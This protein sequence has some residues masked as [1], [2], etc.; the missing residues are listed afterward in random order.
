MVESMQPEAPKTPPSSDDLKFLAF[1]KTFVVSLKEP[2]L[3]NFRKNALDS[4]MICDRIRSTGN[5]IDRCFDEVIDD[6]VQKRIID[7]TKL[8]YTSSEA[9]YANI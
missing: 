4:L 5:F 9:E 3:R 7:K 1:W 6:E 8:E 2:G